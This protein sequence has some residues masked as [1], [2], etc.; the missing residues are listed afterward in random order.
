MTTT[1]CDKIPKIHQACSNSFS[2]SN[3]H[4]LPCFFWN[5]IFPKKIQTWAKSNEI[6]VFLQRSTR[7]FHATYY[8]LEFA[9]DVCKKAKYFSCGVKKIQNIT[10]LYGITKKLLYVTSLVLYKAQSLRNSYN[11]NIQSIETASCA[12]SLFSTIWTKD[13]MKFDV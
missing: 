1:T 3:S 10:L 11:I 7:K 4:S 6:N 12:E 5:K 8:L 13:L 9:V 2:V